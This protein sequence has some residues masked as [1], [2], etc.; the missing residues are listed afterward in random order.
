M[1]RE[2]GGGAVVGVIETKVIQIER[3]VFHAAV[4]RVRAVK[5]L[6]VVGF[7]KFKRLYRNE[8]CPEHIDLPI[9][10]FINPFHAFKR[11]ASVG[12]IQRRHSAL[13]AIQQLLASNS[14]GEVAGQ[15]GVY[16]CVENVAVIAVDAARRQVVK[17]QNCAPLGLWRI[18]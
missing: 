11:A 7:V 8:V 9:A 2:T 4:N 5:A 15:L 13:S 3:R 10:L 16:K 17:K 6:A 14:K 18:L 1:D 12:P